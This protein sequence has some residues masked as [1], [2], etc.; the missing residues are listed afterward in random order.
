MEDCLSNQTR[1]LDVARSRRHAAEETQEAV[2][3]ERKRFLKGARDLD[4]AGIK[5]EGLKVH[6]SLMRR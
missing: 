6:L 1:L 2:I 4:E 3:E 5:Y